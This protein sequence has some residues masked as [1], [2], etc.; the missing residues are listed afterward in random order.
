MACTGSV[1]LLVEK[2]QEMNINGC[3]EQVFLSQESKHMQAL[4]ENRNF[5]GV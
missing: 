4:S 3:L 2:L 5:L 1:G